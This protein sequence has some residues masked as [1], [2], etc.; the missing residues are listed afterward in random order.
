MTP[1][2]PRGPVR[3]RRAGSRADFDIALELLERHHAIV[4]D[5]VTHR[6]GLDAIQSAFATASDKRSGAI[7]VS[8]LP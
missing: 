6:L 5:V 4:A 8:L 1:R 3:G 2:P 7:K